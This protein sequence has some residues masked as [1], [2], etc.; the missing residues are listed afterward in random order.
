[1]GTVSVAHVE[2]KIGGE[3]VLFSTT[4]E[5]IEIEE[6]RRNAHRCTPGTGVIG[7]GCF[8]FSAEACRELEPADFPFVRGMLLPERPKYGQ[9]GR[10]RRRRELCEARRINEFIQGLERTTN[11]ADLEAVKQQLISMLPNRFDCPGCGIGVA[12]DEDGCCATCGRHCNA[13]EDGKLVVKAEAYDL[14]GSDA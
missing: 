13:Y 5:E 7:E 3:S 12:A 1:M 9:P 14:E 2:V 11:I 6:D 4:I 10:G 8:D